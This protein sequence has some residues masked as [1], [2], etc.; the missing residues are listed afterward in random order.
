MLTLFKS[1]LT[2]ARRPI[3]ILGIGAL[4]LGVL[5][6]GACASAPATQSGF[7]SDYSRLEARTDIVRARVLQF[8]DEALVSTIERVLIEPVQLGEGVGTNLTEAERSLL[9]YELDRQVCYEVSRRFDL[10]TAADAA[11]PRLRLAAT[12]VQITNQAG[13]V[14]SAVADRFI[15]GPIGLR[16]PGSTGGLAAEMELLMPDGRQAAALVWSRDAQVVGTDN[17]S[18]SRIGDAHQ[19][20]EP[21]GDIVGAGVAPK[22]RRPRTVP[23]PDPCAQYGPRIRPEGFVT[24]FVTGLYTPSISGG[25]PRDRAAPRADAPQPQAEPQSQPL[26]P[27]PPKVDWRALMPVIPTLPASEV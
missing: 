19:L 14:A 15:P 13:S 4:G 17:P 24:R 9:V 6:L 21:F 26:A 16:V 5:S 20:A 27:V 3:T 18:L 2:T 1:A 8:R 25:G 22:D 10:A 11:A 12:R 7:L 23:D